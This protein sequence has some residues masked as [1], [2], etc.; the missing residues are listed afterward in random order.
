MAASSH[1][2]LNRREFLRLVGTSG[3]GLAL[4]S[5]CRSG[6][7][8]G[9]T[10]WPMAPPTQ[11]APFSNRCSTLPV[12]LSQG[13]TVKWTEFYSTMTPEQENA[14]GTNA[15]RGLEWMANVIRQFE[16]DNRG[17]KFQL[18]P[19]RSDQLDQRLAVDFN[20]N[21]DHDLVFSSPERMSRHRKLGDLL[22]LTPYVQGLSPADVED[23]NWNAVWRAASVGGQ[24]LGP[25]HQPVHLRPG[26]QSRAVRGRPASLTGP[27][28]RLT[29]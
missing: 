25:P 23:L 27:S 26:L 2:P 15:T 6:A 10:S 11:L 12:A 3:A 29:W 1:G 19:V 21:T 9:A 13:G 4:L 14:T 24:Q 17:W 8:K 28:N 5:V 20:A 18:E 22:D 16:A 7:P